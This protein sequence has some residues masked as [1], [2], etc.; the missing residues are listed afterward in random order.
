MSLCRPVVVAALAAF[1]LP[2]GASALP[3][4][5]LLSDPATATFS[6]ALAVG[7]DGTAIAAWIQT[8]T[9]PKSEVM[10]ATRP[11]GGAWSA[12]VAVSDP[13]LTSP[14]T[15][16][17]ALDG[18]GD[19]A[20]AWAASAAS[21]A[22]STYNTKIQTVV[23]GAGGTWSAPSDLSPATAFGQDGSAAGAPTVA[24]DAAGD[25]T[26]AWWPYNDASPAVDVVDRPHDGIW[27][28][29]STVAAGGPANPSPQPRLVED[30]AGDAAVSWRNPLDT[31]SYNG[32]GTARVALRAAGS[33]S[34]SAPVDVSTPG[35]TIGAGTIGLGIDSGG[36]ATAA[37]TDTTHG[38]VEAATLAPGASAGS[39]PAQVGAG[40]N[41][42]TPTLA[43]TGDGAA[44]L[45]WLSEDAS[46]KRQVVVAAH[47]ATG[48]GPWSPA[49]AL[50]GA[51]RYATTLS[52]A[53]A[54]GGVVRAVWADTDRIDGGPPYPPYTVRVDRFSGLSWDAMT[55]LTAQADSA[56][57]PI[58]ALSPTGDATTVWLSKDG[59]TVTRVR[60]ALDDVTPPTLSLAVPAGATA[61]DDVPFSV[62]TSDA[63]GGVGVSWSFGDGTPATSGAAVTHAFAVAGT[64][65]VTATATDAAGNATSATATITISAPPVPPAPTPSPTPTPTPS[66]SPTPTPS[67]TP[68]PT[69]ASKPV[70]GS[71]PAT[72]NAASV[73]ALPAASKSC[74]SRRTLKITLHAPKGTTIARTTVSV[75]GRKAMSYTGSRAHAPITLTGLPKGTYTVTVKVT[76]STKKTLTL[77]RKYKTCAP[78]RK[79]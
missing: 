41:L 26:V 19:A 69:P 70:P 65:T 34:W 15:P 79:K 28:A 4:S 47:R 50:S 9:S 64:Y 57:S 61:G 63:G 52:L 7:A 71:K 62:T 14:Q 37:W 43:E 58:V 36:V 73:I 54:P 8:T 74:T 35:D 2:A 45:A 11:A 78:K 10:V 75:T 23:R 32:P 13:D 68:S 22:P 29:I 48:S 31:T 5:T 46:L 53:A 67:P 66:P 1:A 18:S 3:S 49:P 56:S 76:L 55:D 6:P 16:A 42:F 60:A 30:A 40:T 33:S 51:D 72:T 39:A 38:A 17:I 44:T 20:V 25:T 24:M 27:S 77:A 12:P 59:T 21:G